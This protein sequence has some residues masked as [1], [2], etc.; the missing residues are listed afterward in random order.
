MAQ[1]KGG[2]HGDPP[3][4]DDGGSRRRGRRRRTVLNLGTPFF[5]VDDFVN[6][7][8]EAVALGY[9]VLVETIEEIKSGYEEAKEFSNRQRDF[10]EKQRK[11]ERG[12]GPRPT[13]PPIPWEQLVERVQKFQTIAFDAVRGGTELFFDSIKSGTKSTERLARTWNQS[14]TDIDATP[15]LAGPVFEDP[16]VIEA[17]AG[18][19]P[20]P[21]V[22]P[23]RHRGLTRLRIRAIVDPWPVAVQRARKRSATAVGSVPRPEQAPAE[24]FAGKVHVTFQ[25]AEDLNTYDDA[26]SLLTVDVGRIP[27]DQRAGTY[28]GLIRAVDFALLIAP[29]RI[30]VH[31]ADKE[32]SSPWRA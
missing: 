18:E 27:P 6:Q 10:E 29:L 1:P 8:E 12:E 30:C 2:S 17:R 3:G 13:P 22:M 26:T 5:P 7:S 24:S 21:V 11:F 19:N 23:I 32:S 28:E 14:R 31:K 15:V 9:R 4:G 25:P 16:V 20:R